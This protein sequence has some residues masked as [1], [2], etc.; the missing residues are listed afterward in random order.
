MWLRENVVPQ[1]S[2]REELRF[3]NEGKVYFRLC[4]DK[5]I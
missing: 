3:Q 5:S 1:I 4:A 2:Y